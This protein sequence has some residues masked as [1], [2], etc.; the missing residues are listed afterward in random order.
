MTYTLSESS[1]GTFSVTSG[2]SGSKY[3]AFFRQRAANSWVAAGMA[4][5]PGL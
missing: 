5:V 1:T 4:G 3:R 2:S